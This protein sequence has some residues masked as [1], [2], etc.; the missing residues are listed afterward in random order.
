MVDNSITLEN[1]YA[2]LSARLPGLSRDSH[3]LASPN[4]LVSFFFPSL[5]KSLFT[6]KQIITNQ[7][8][9]YAKS[10]LPIQAIPAGQVLSITAVTIF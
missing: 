8:V 7:I 9:E 6:T 4:G 10:G 5:H 3:S 1:I 2:I